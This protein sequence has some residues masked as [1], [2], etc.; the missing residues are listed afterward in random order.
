[1]V[2]GSRRLPL[3]FRLRMEI[4][5]YYADDAC[6]CANFDGSRIRIDSRRTSTGLSHRHANLLSSKYRP[7][8]DQYAASARPHT[9]RR[10]PRTHDALD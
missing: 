2:L 3:L 5:R 1:M 7:I 9:E 6:A 8:C 10:S 4:W